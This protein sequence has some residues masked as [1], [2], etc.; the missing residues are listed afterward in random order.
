MGLNESTI[1]ISP[2]PTKTKKPRRPEDP[3]ES[4]KEPNRNRLTAFTPGRIRASYK[5]KKSPD[6][7]NPD[8]QNYPNVNQKSNLK[9]PKNGKKEGPGQVYYK[10]QMP[11]LGNRPQPEKLPV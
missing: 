4:E 7:E 6:Q 2:K 3:F 5:G 11:V 8:E 10:I 9:T 1:R